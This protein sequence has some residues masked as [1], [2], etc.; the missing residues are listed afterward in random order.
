MD[1]SSLVVLRCAGS[2]VAVFAGALARALRAARPDRTVIVDAADGDVPW[3]P[4]PGEPAA[5]VRLVFVCG[6]AVD[7]LRAQLPASTRPVHLTAIVV[8]PEGRDPG[9]LVPAVAL[10]RVFA[11]VVGVEGAAQMLHGLFDG[12]EREEA[13]DTDEW[14]AP[15]EDDFGMPDLDDDGTVPP[16][17]STPTGASGL[18]EFRGPVPAAPPPPR[19]PQ[20]PQRSSSATGAGASQTAVTDTRPAPAGQVTP[21][22]PPLPAAPAP[23]AAMPRSSPPPAATII[24]G[25]PPPAGPGPSAPPPLPPSAAVPPVPRPVAAAP[26]KSTATPVDPAPSDG[27]KSPAA[28]MAK[29]LKRIAGKVEDLAASVVNDWILRA[30]AEAPSASDPPPAVVPASGNAAPGSSAPPSPVALGA[31]APRAAAIGAEFTARFIAHVPGRERAVAARLADL[32]PDGRAHL[33]VKQ[34]QWAPGTA[35]TVTLRARGL[36]VEP[37]ARTFTW[38]GEEQVEEFDVTVPAATPPGTLVLK[39]DAAI[40][41]IV[42]ATLRVDLVVTAAATTLK[43]RTSATTTA[44]R[45]AFA[46]YASADRARVLDRIAAVRIAAGLDVFVDCLSLHPG[47]TW[48]ARLDAEIRARDVFLLF[49]SASASQSDEVSWEWRTAV[50]ARGAEA[51]QL[52]PLDPDVHP[53]AELADRHAGDGLMWVRRATVPRSG[54]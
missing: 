28:K 3:S 51:V 16:W 47:D 8:A 39:F 50:A 29:G 12:D 41:G 53:P 14:L 22:A 11:D 49:W 9:G 2:D 1:V 48:R 46:S 54:A 27:V 33:N 23:A 18:E 40:E 45:T 26:A 42:V 38:N 20:A 10:P 19:R 21:A 5:P 32:S 52:H 30:P 17:P 36:Q 34:C 35:V 4:P 44:A 31:S 43:A 13:R 25:A 24:V 6:D 15:E 7:P 37:P